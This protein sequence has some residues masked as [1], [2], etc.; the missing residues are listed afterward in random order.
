MMRL[1]SEPCGHWDSIEHVNRREESSG[2]RICRLDVIFDNYVSL[3]NSSTSAG[4]LI[5]TVCAFVGG[6][7]P[8]E[9]RYQWQ[10][11]MDLIRVSR[12]LCELLHCWPLMS[13]PTSR[14]SHGDLVC[15]CQG[16]RRVWTV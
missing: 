3:S 15:V 1:N 10:L 13:S 9:P 2:A 11:N 8:R 6:D 7:E 14:Q 16:E 12:Q 5:S 4:N